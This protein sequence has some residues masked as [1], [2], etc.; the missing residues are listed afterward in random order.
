MTSA[1]GVGAIA[2]GERGAPEADERKGGCVNF[3]LARETRSK[4]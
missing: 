3:I 2:I 4:I 1:L